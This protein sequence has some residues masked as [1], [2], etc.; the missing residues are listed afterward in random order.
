MKKAIALLLTV[1]LI[2]LAGCTPAQETSGSTAVTT[3]ETTLS[4]QAGDTTVGICLPNQTDQRWIN[5][6][7][8][9]A[10]LLENMGFQPLLQDAQDDPWLQEE[11]ISQLIAQEADCLVIAAVDSLLL[12]EVLQQAKQKN[13]PVVAYDRMLTQTDAVSC[14]VAFEYEAV[15]LAIAEYIITAK[16][17]KT[18][19]AEGRSYTIE[20]LMGSPEDNNAL[21]LY[22]GIMHSLQSYL[23]SGVLVCPSGRV[24]F[25]DTCIR[26]WSEQLA[27]ER[28][29]EFLTPEETPDILCA[30]SDSIAQGC[31]LALADIGTQETWPLITGQDA[32]EAALERIAQGTHAM[33]VYK[34]TGLL[35]EKCAQAVQSLLA[36]TL[37]AD[38]CHNGMIEVPAVF[39]L[40]VTVDQSNYQEFPNIAQ[41]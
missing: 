37:S 14:Y 1:S 5:D 18:A 17:L 29:G 16:Q 24:S 4:A 36:G 22:T 38:T 27:T 9:L 39:C 21:L 33:T 41:S 11:Q 28:C 13:I 30:A 40:P 15:G 34:D 10:G 8:T 3:A 12:T 35:A 20:F 2:L 6:G 23:D 31:A 7:A 26:G 19:Q 32:Q 25:E